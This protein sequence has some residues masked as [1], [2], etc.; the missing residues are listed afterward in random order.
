MIGD[1][2]ALCASACGDAFEVKTVY[3]AAVDQYA[4]AKA[5]DKGV[6]GAANSRINTYSNYFPEKKDV[7]FRNL[8][9]G[10]SYTLKCWPNVTTTI[11][12]K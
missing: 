11:R 6:A 9:D 12:S 8:T 3:W 7:F 4:K 2:Y 1:S 10:S 5:A